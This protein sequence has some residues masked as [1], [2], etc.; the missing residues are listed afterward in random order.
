[1][2]PKK[3]KQGRETENSS[4]ERINL[5]DYDS[6]KGKDSFHD[7]TD[8][9]TTSLDRNLNEQIGG[10]DNTVTSEPNHI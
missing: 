9:S 4:H 8:Q 7:H 3:N 10:T 1:M 5:N 2:E 6:N